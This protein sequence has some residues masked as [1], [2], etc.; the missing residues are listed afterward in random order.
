MLV[1]Y[2]EHRPCLSTFCAQLQSNER[3]CLMLSPQASVLSCVLYSSSY[4][5]DLCALL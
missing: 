1:P 3:A 5:S 2:I 4:I